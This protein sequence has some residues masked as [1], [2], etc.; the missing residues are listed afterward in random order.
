[1]TI[2]LYEIREPNDRMKE[3]EKRQNQNMFRPLLP[4]GKGS[5]VGF[6]ARRKIIVALF[7]AWVLRS[8]TPFASVGRE[9]M[10]HDGSLK[11]SRKRLNESNYGRN[12]SVRRGV[13]FNDFP[14]RSAV[15]AC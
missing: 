15:A 8:Y 11:W 5:I 2:D 9:R 3:E 12:L 14:K 1:M 7:Y 6:R 13:F 10:P 4:A